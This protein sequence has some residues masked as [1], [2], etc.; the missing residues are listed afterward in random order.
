MNDMSPGGSAYYEQQSP[1]L[2]AAQPSSLTKERSKGKDWTRI[3]A[4]VESRIGVDLW[5]A[6]K[7]LAQ[8]GINAGMK[9]LGVPRRNLL[10]TPLGKAV[11]AAFDRTRASGGCA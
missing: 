6:L 10:E 4:H 3:Y 8:E 5:P 1:T 7:P 11:S 9:A 2:L